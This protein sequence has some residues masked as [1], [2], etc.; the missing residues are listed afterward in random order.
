LTDKSLLKIVFYRQR[1]LTVPNHRHEGGM[2]MHISRN[3]MIN[4]PFFM[5]HSSPTAIAQ[6][7]VADELT[8][9]LFWGSAARSTAL[10]QKRLETGSYADRR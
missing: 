5:P 9:N 10:P 3:E 4:A 6:P 2:M 7:R 8:S 1:S